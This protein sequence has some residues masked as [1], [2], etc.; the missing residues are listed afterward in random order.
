MKEAVAWRGADITTV[1]SPV[2]EHP[3]PLQPANV[4]PLAAVAVS[5]TV[6]P[7]SNRALQLLPQSTLLGRL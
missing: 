4:D 7:N 2:P 5:T 6:W 1:Q 3:E